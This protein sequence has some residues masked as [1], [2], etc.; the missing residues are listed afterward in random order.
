MF[1]RHSVVIDYQRSLDVIYLIDASECRADATVNTENLVCDN[2][3][4]WEIFE[5]FVDFGEDGISPLW[6]F[7][8][9]LPFTLLAAFAMHM[10]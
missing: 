5:H 2:C 8:S 9:A 6:L 3:S 7:L 1:A 10:L 4:E